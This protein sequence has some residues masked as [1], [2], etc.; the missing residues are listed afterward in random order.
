MI[1]KILFFGFALLTCFSSF[2]QTLIQKPSYHR[3]ANTILSDVEKTT[4]CIDIIEYPQSKS[5]NYLVDTMDVVTYIG[6]IGQ[7]YYY[8]GTGKVHGINAYMLLDLDGIPANKDSV[9][10]VISVRNVDAGNVPTTIIASDTV[11]LYDV[12]FNAQNLMFSSPINVSDTFAVVLSIDALHPSHPYYVTNDYGN[13][14]IE[15]LSSLSYTGTWYNLYP[16]WG[17]TWDVDMIISPIFEDIL[18]PSF[19]VDTNTV[20]LGNPITFTNITNFTLNSM[21]NPVSPIYSLYL[22]ESMLSVNFDS[23]YTHTYSSSAIFNPWL[24]LVQ[25]GYTVNCVI[26]SIKTISVIDSASANFSFNHLGGG[27]YQFTDMS[28]NANTWS[29]NFGD[30]SAVYTGPNP[31]YT[32]STP[33]S[34]QV[35]LTVQDSNGCNISTFCQPVSFTVGQKENIKTNE[36]KIYP[37]PATRFFNVE[38]PS[39]FVNPEI[40]VTDIVGKKIISIDHIRQNKVKVLTDEVDEGVYFVTVSSNSQKVFTKKIVVDK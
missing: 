33:G 6:E 30:S 23:S 10:V 27:M 40:S 28:T 32:Y 31:I 25:N 3:I 37:I 19:V 9:S 21:F 38:L 14:G 26:D 7:T 1:R 13:G 12:G 22:D 20:C 36:V 39:N 16:T 34:Y 18:T 15:K 17:G 29:W 8:T 5:T 2:S 24:E 11:F 35:C 4:S